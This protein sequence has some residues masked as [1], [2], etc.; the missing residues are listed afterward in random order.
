MPT[1]ATPTTRKPRK[2]KTLDPELAAMAAIADLLGTLPDEA[3]RMRVMRWSFERFCPEL[4]V[5]VLPAATVSSTPVEE[6][7]T[8]LPPGPDVDEVIAA[9][10]DAE[11]AEILTSE[12][13]VAAVAAD[14]ED[15]QAQMSELH[16]LFAP[17]PEIPDRTDAYF[18]LSGL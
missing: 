3:T 17:A 5:A 12:P 2:K 8:A 18:D 13:G 10:V 6:V 4:P 14:L 11:P 7:P 1:P 15:F 16:D 9:P